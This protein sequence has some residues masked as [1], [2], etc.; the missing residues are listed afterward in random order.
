MPSIYYVDT[1]EMGFVQDVVREETAGSTV[2]FTTFAEATHGHEDFDEDKAT[3]DELT[4]DKV[5]ARL[6][7]TTKLVAFVGEIDDMSC[8]TISSAAN[9]DFHSLKIMRNLFYKEKE[10]I[11]SDKFHKS[12]PYLGVDEID[13]YH[14]T[15]V[16]RDPITG[17]RISNLMVRSDSSAPYTGTYPGLFFAEGWCSEQLSLIEDGRI[18]Y[19]DTD[20]AGA[21][22]AGSFAQ[23]GKMGTTYGMGI[24]NATTGVTTVEAG[25]VTIERG[26]GQSDVDSH[27][28]FMVLD[29]AGAGTPTPQGT[30]DSRGTYTGWRTELNSDIPILQCRKNDG[31]GDVLWSMRSDGLMEFENYPIDD[32]A[33]AAAGSAPPISIHSVVTG[34]SSVYIGS[35]KISFDRAAHEIVFQKLKLTGLPKYFDDLGYTNANLPSGY[36]LAAMSVQRYLALARDLQ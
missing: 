30:I 4:T 29:D 35:G 22:I 14:Q 20:V 5:T 27:V 13:T 16:V 31:T 7:D 18:Y 10:Y 9:A 21:N 11:I 36:N 15:L 17:C 32:P 1:D 23:F 8:H 19:A 3:I 28:V 25:R 6:V 12:G 2:V 26:T 33:H 34:D 24:E